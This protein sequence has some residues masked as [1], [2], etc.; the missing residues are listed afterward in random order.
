MK[1]Q[2]QNQTKLNTN[3]HLIAYLI[4]TIVL[5]AIFVQALNAAEN[6][7]D[8]SVVESNFKLTN[9]VGT[10][11][12]LMR[13]DRGSEYQV[14][15]LLDTQASVS[16]SGPVASTEIT[17]S[18]INSGVDF[19]ES[20]YVFPL[21]EHSA[22]EYME[23]SVGDRRI[24]GQIMEK[25]QAKQVYTQAKRQGNRAALVQQSRPNLFKTSVANIPAGERVSVTL[26]IN[27]SLTVQSNANTGMQNFE[28]RLPLTLTPRYQ[29]GSINS[30][31]IISDNQGQ[32]QKP[33][34]NIL[35]NPDTSLADIFPPQV[36]TKNSSGIENP[37]NIDVQIHNI[38]FQNRVQSLNQKVEQTVVDDIRRINFSQ[39]NVAMDQDFVLKW[40]INDGSENQAQFF[41]Q[42]VD[43][44]EYGL[45]ML[46]APSINTRSKVLPRE[47][48][49][50][51]D[52]SG[53]MG[54]ASMHQAKESLLFALDNLAVD[55]R[56][57]IIDFDSRFT[58]LFPEPRSADTKMLKKAEKFVRKLR[59]DGG[60][61]MAEP[62]AAALAMRSDENYLKQ[63]IFITDGSVS[64]EQQL[65]SLLDKNLGKSRLFT[66]GIGSAPNSYFMRKAAEFGRGSFTYIGSIDE[67]KPQMSDLFKK[68]GSPVLQDLELVF[69]DGTN[70]EIWP[71]FIPDLYAGEPVIIPI[72]FENR[73][74]W[75]TIK[76]RSDQVWVRN[77]TI[78]QEQENPG[79]SSLWARKKIGSLMD[80]MVRGESEDKIKPQVLEV[81]LS[82]HLL[83]KYTSFVAV[84]ES[85]VRANR[86]KLK[87]EQIPNLLPK[88]NNY[89]STATGLSLWII[90]TFIA[91]IL[92]LFMRFTFNSP[93]FYLVTRT[94]E[95]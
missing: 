83:S 73:P 65:F 30:E 46:S 55:E 48:I 32:H 75:V 82:H 21:A 4:I 23:I 95:A 78:N 54:G 28:Y 17:Q 36:Q 8:L 91:L 11:T 69:P 56:F 19:S 68:L 77:I 49:F 67:V 86:A 79:I 13:S 2:I 90:L 94:R 89:P 37:I 60:T 26:R 92:S 16:I 80:K 58:K 51:I 44:D 59:A 22:V 84:D 9:D 71:E 88:G 50:I 47:V 41:T 38:L 81:A 42:H 72:K 52:S 63:I 15:T 7:N 39:S 93:S 12:L 74:A 64:N 85:I 57:N 61:N 1:N 3:I 14:A 62:L 66:V 29:P 5:S 6:A 34:S 24:I 53:S 87:T 20:I 35:K 27:Q 33:L 40:N 76:G 10:G 70:A 18:F 45:L 31:T 43:G 25:E